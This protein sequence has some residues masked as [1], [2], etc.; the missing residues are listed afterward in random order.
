MKNFIL[1]SAAR[2]QNTADAAAKRRAYHH[3]TYSKQLQAKFGPSRRTTVRDFKECLQFNST[4]H[5]AADP[6]VRSAAQRRALTCCMSRALRH[7][8]DARCGNTVQRVGLADATGARSKVAKIVAGEQRRLLLLLL[9][10]RVVIL[11]THAVCVMV[12]LGVVVYMNHDRH[13]DPRCDTPW[14]CSRRPL[15]PHVPVRHHL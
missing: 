7:A 8:Q 9:Y 14:C 13:R 4:L 5:A 1:E 12:G 11:M 2:T 10:M 15:L 3:D 6:V